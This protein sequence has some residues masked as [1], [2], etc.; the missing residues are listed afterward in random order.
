LFER[1]RAAAARAVAVSV[2]STDFPDVPGHTLGVPHYPA[3]YRDSASVSERRLSIEVGP[4]TRMKPQVPENPT[5]PKIALPEEFRGRITL[6]IGETVTATGFG[7]SSLYEAIRRG[8]LGVIRKG[9]R[10]LV[11]VAGLLEWLAA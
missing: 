4:R 9:R 7:R 11:P 10:T 3:K 1:E 6:S 5:P 8:E 2:F